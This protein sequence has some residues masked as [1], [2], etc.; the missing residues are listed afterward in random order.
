M[1]NTLIYKGKELKWNYNICPCLE[2][3]LYPD[4]TKWKDDPDKRNDKCYT[5]HCSYDKQQAKD[6][7]AFVYDAMHNYHCPDCGEYWSK[8]EIHNHACP[9]Y[10]IN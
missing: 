2:C 5:S 1:E 3:P 8:D 7:A 9:N 10:T 4:I 6:V